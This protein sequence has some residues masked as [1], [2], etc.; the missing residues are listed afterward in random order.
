LLGIHFRFP[1]LCLLVALTAA[2]VRNIQ[3]Y[4]ALGSGRRKMRPQ[5]A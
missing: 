5:A 4:S 2:Q 1:Y 3:L